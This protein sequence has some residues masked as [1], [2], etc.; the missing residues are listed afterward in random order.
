MG[1][2]FT[3][4]D[5]KV[6]KTC[7]NTPTSCQMNETNFESEI[8]GPISCSH[9]LLDFIEKDRGIATLLMLW[10]C[11]EVCPGMGN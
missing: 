6:M 4:F 3:I 8:V 10:E 7:G 2:V 5:G 11:G 9:F 1:P